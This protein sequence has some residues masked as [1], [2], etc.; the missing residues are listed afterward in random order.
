MV[1][2]AV[3]VAVIE[4]VTVEVGIGGTVTPDLKAAM[5]SADSA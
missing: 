4:G 2:V 5:S 1:G 3:G